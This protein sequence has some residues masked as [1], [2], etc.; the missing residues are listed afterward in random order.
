MTSSI[1]ER[2]RFFAIKNNVDSYAFCTYLGV[3]Y[4]MWGGWLLRMKPWAEIW[5]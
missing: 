1:S 5:N 4:V 2:Q 3:K